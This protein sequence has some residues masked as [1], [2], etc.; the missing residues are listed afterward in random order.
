MCIYA[1]I[2]SNCCVI[3][4]ILPWYS[5][6]YT[7][8]FVYLLH[9]LSRVD[10]LELAVSSCRVRVLMVWFNLYRY[11]ISYALMAWSLFKVYSNDAMIDTLS[12]NKLI[13]ILNSSI[14]CTDLFS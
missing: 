1:L 5:L 12:S 2:L 11:A 3:D 4:A 6:I 7:W 13:F 14:C 8:M 10:N 9:S